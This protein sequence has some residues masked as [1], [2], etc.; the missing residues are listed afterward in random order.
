MF[1]RQ[2][3]DHIPWRFKAIQREIAGRP[4]VSHQFTLGFVILD[5][6]V[7]HGGVPQWHKC[8]ANGGYGPLR[9]DYVGPC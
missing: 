6:P 2:N 4:K 9:C 5:R 8:I 1:D 7:D 3:G